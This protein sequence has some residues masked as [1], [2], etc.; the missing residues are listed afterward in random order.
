MTHFCE[1]NSRVSKEGTSA[2]GRCPVPKGTLTY[3]KVNE[4]N[5]KIRRKKEVNLHYP[6]LFIKFAQ[7]NT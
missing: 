7:Q 3:R 5:L 4:K 2:K 1:K 6:I